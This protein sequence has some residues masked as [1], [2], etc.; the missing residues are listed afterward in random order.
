MKLSDAL[1]G[2]N[3]L[4]YDSMAAYN[5][6]LNMNTKFSSKGK[7]ENVINIPKEIIAFL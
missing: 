2:K 1:P 6:L 5:K 4:P 3:K 7:P